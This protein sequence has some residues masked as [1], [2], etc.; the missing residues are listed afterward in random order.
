LWLALYLLSLSRSARVL[1]TD[2]EQIRRAL[3]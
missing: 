1:E 2:H 3:S